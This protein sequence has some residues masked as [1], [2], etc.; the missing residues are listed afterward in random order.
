MLSL[1]PSRELAVS[2]R[3]ALVADHDDDAR[4][5]SASDCNGLQQSRVAFDAGDNV[6]MELSHFE[7]GHQ[8]SI[9]GWTDLLGHPMEI[10]AVTV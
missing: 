8:S 9:E 7:V 4:C 2:I 6:V 5:A 10:V 3:S 1:P